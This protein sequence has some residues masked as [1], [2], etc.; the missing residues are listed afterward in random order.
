MTNSELIMTVAL[1]IGAIMTGIMNMIKAQNYVNAKYIPLVALFVG[2]LV[3]VI[4]G[5]FVFDVEPIIG[6]IA[7][8]IAGLTSVGFYEGGK[9]VSNA[10][11]GDK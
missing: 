11:S 6:A 5:I 10:I 7:G 8:I 4:G 3:G 2:V 9:S 1:G